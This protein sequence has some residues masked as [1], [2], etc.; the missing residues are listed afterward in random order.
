MYRF[1]H[2]FFGGLRCI[3]HVSSATSDTDSNNESWTSKASW[4]LEKVQE[5]LLCR[6]LYMTQYFRVFSRVF[7]YT[8][9][10]FYLM[11]MDSFFYNF[12]SK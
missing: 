9:Q 7:N 5:G 6:I 4:Y 11:S 12:M 3:A 2:E 8:S 1:F 10:L